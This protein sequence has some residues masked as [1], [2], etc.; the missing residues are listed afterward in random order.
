MQPVLSSHQMHSKDLIEVVRLGGKPLNLLS[1]WTTLQACFYFDS[2]IK[3]Y[4]EL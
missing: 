4:E 1:G 3:V 2:S